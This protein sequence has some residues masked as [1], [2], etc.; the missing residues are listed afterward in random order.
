ML[1]RLLTKADGN[2]Y[3]KLRLESLANDPAAFLTTLESEKKLHEDVFANHIDWSYHPPYFGYLGIFVGN[4]N[5]ELAGYLQVSQNF[6]EKQGHIAAINNVYLSPRWRGRGLATQLF[7]YVFHLLKESGHI[8]R[9]YLS[10]TASNQ[11]AQHLYHQLGFQRYAVKV[12]AVKWQGKY[13]DEVEFVKV[14]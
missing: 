11:H 12:K 4:D 13:D 9:V 10:C 8:E 7:E 2:T 6:L 3:Q 5:T 1:I 14:L